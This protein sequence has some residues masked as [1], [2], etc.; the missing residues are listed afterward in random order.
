[1]LPE[2]RHTV[3]VLLLSWE[4]GYW[5]NF[6]G[7]SGA[8]LRTYEIWQVLPTHIFQN[9]NIDF[10]FMSMFCGSLCAFYIESILVTNRP[11]VVYLFP[12]KV[13]IFNIVV[14]HHIVLFHIGRIFISTIYRWYN[15]KIYKHNYCVKKWAQRKAQNCAWHRKFEVGPTLHIWLLLNRCLNPKSHNQGGWE[16][17]WIQNTTSQ[18]IVRVLVYHCLRLGLFDLDLDLH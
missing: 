4:K 12:R 11:L 10:P 5:W 2:W 17:V 13:C 3:G 8:F 1:V 18:R 6:D 16:F 14:S 9:N 15:I 7:N